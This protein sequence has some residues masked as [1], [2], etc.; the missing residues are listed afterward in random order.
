MDTPDNWVI[1]KIKHPKEI[2][3]KI[4]AGWSGGYLDGDSWRMN[5]GIVKVQEE[6]NHILFHGY[7]GSVYKC[8]K[9][10]EMIRMN[11][12]GIWKQLKEA[13]PDLVELIEYVDFVKEF[14]DLDFYKKEV[15]S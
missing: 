2:M 10:S 11:S 14:K 9:G 12:A 5:S 6:G 13:H 1:I 3:Y 15:K 7:S 4:L 8:R